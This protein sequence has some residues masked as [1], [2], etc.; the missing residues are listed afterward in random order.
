MFLVLAFMPFESVFAMITTYESFVAKDPHKVEI[1][2]DI[3][4]GQLGA[5]IVSGDFNRDGID[6]LV[7]SAPFAST[8]MNQW[9]GEV[10]IFFG[11]KTFIERKIDLSIDRP[12]IVIFG[13]NSGDQFGTAMEV[14]DYNNDGNDDLLISAPN[15]YNNGERPGKVYLF[16]GS[17]DSSLKN[18]SAIDLSLKKADAT[19]IGR[20]D[21]DAFGLSLKTMDLDGNGI[22][23]FLI[24]SP[25]ASAYDI[26]NCGAVY[27]FL[28]SDRKFLQNTDMLNSSSNIIFYG[29]KSGEKFGS[30]VTGG[31]F[32]GYRVSDVAI[33]AYTAKVG[34]LDEAGKVYIYKGGVG[35]SSIVKTSTFS[36]DGVD[37]KSWFG[38]AMD[39]ADLNG[40]SL[41]DL[42]ITSFPYSSKENTG[43]VF[44]FF[45]GTK[46][47][48]EDVDYKASDFKDIIIENPKNES[49]LGASV[50]LADFNKDSIKDIVMGAPGIGNPSS[51]YPGNVYIA[52]SSVDGFLPTYN[53]GDDRITSQILGENADDWFGYSLTALDLNADGYEDLAVGSRYSDTNVGINSGKVFTLLGEGI[54]YGTA[55]EIVEPK[56]K[57]VTRGEFLKSV[58]TKFN[59]A[60]KKKNVLSDCKKHID[61][62]LFNFSTISTFQKMEFY[63]DLVLYPDIYPIN[64]YHEYVN[65]G[66]ML[67]FLTGFTG[68]ENTPFHV[69]R[70]ISR[71]QALKIILG[72]A[73]LVQPRYKFELV[74][75]LGSL[76]KLIEQ[77]SFFIDIDPKISFMWWYP[78][79][80]N[81]AYE[82]DLVD[83]VYFFR[84][85]ENITAG[86]LD[87]ILNR[88]MKIIEST[89]EEVKP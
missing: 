36:I 32:L 45:G 24:G 50:K 23:D 22:N 29:Q 2:G 85:D 89:N 59:L 33:G 62:C 17:Y 14:G 47:S 10:F 28:G 64:P 21:K 75:M 1:L 5:S 72:A 74:A 61:F 40:D 69:E 30:V 67:G 70:H 56:D 38:F 73:D 52:Y 20:A 41:D 35:F 44:V 60:E 68:E 77:E 34:D 12:N 49:F 66:T 81:Y 88:T 65:M 76:Q 18:D 3:A 51:E 42:A 48:Q 31:H 54:P 37:K 87:D 86:E 4:G 79:Y 43:K 39:S 27:G 53:I 13:E 9:N 58:F 46:F 71:I 78:R 25:N 63:P 84:P 16:Y 6:D 26:N 15:A 83:H 19:F 80:A 7:M 11:K 57:P 8:G 82:N 55:K